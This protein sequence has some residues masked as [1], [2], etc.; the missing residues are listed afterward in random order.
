[1]LCE[2]WASRLQEIV[3]AD[4][5]HDVAVGEMLK[6]YAICAD[7]LGNWAVKL[8][9][10]AAL[11]AGAGALPSTASPRALIQQ[12]EVEFDR[13]RLATLTPKLIATK[14]TDNRLDWIRFDC[15]C[16][17]F[18]EERIAREAA[19]CVSED[20]LTLDE[21]AADAHEKVG[22][23]NFYADEIEAGI[24]PYFLAAQAGD[25][26]GPL[27]IRQS[28]PLFSLVK[29]QLPAADDPHIL[30]RAE[31]AIITSLTEEAINERVQWAA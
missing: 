14:I 22:Q 9:G 29:K 1:L 27:K 3:A 8:A 17:W 7:K 28:F 4:P 30:A 23:W 20:G 26:L 2:R 21:V 15:H 6:S 10:R 11:V 5:L 12:I 25:L 16:L 19:W 13:L 31:R 18:S 24:R